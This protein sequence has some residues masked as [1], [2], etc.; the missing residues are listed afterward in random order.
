MHPV[1]K[2]NKLF[3]QKNKL[4]IKAKSFHKNTLTKEKYTEKITDFEYW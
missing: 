1:F 3:W 2:T 4:H